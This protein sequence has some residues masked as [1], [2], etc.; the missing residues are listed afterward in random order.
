[1]QIFNVKYVYFNQTFTFILWLMCSEEHYIYM[2]HQIDGA[3]GTN[4]TDGADGRNGT[5]RSRW[6][7]LWQRLF[8]WLSSLFDSVYFVL[9][10]LWVCFGV[11][12]CV[13]GLTLEVCL[14]SCLM[15][16][17]CLGYE[18]SSWKM[19]RSC[20]WHWIKYR[21]WYK[22]SYAVKGHFL[23]TIMRMVTL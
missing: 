4:G 10:A 7:K 1:M 23:L 16:F 15:H 2:L 5:W 11:N 17:V 22:S 21:N 14:K 19:Q 8:L 12:F 3:D 9:I 13:W 18:H 6:K 20:R